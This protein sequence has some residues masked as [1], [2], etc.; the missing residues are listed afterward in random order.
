[1]LIHFLN[2]VHSYIAL[3]GGLI[4]SIIHNKIEAGFYQMTQKIVIIGAGQAAIAFAAK[5]REL[6]QDAEITMIG[7][8]PSLPYQ[9]PPLSKK[10]MTG[11]MEADRL[12]LRPQAWYEEN[13]VSCVA[14]ETVYSIDVENKQIVLEGAS[15]PYDKLLIAT[16]SRP[17]ELP[18]EIGGFLDGV[19]TLRDLE[20]ADAIGAEI[21][22]GKQVLI[23]GGGYI[24]LE[25]AAV[26][27][28]KG[29]K[30]RVVEMADRILQRV[31]ASQ[32]SDFI[33]A[34]HKSEGVEISENL[35]LDKLI[36][37]EGRVVGA[38]FS[39]GSEMQVDFVLAG[40]GAIANME[41]A[42][43]AG[44][45]CSSGIDVNAQTQTSNEDIFAAGDV[46]AFNFREHNV[47]LESVQNAIDQA[48]HAAKVIAGDT[49]DYTPSPWFWSDQYDIKLQ[50]AGFN[51]GYDETVVRDGS[52]SGGQST[53]Y[54]A[55]GKF[56]AVDAMNDP[57]AYM[58][59]KKI[60]ESGNQLTPDQAKDA[61]FDL[62]SLL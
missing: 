18:A 39:D 44:L 62:K 45:S 3:G 29:M 13:K 50:I 37:K 51:I 26:C 58:F 20:D 31:A 34:K 54:F 25:A 41:L 47:R 16:G 53:W 17:R 15:L 57:K 14:G 8:E 56:I 28:Q 6:D 11:D 36:E 30:V 33:R 38:K 2:I 49:S 24:G 9:R 61:E 52:R 59:G 7:Q 32:T 42:Q 1:M 27:S 40:I 21:G 19:Y 10:Y 12:L 55:D 23:I 48:E 4:V 35:G 46:A 60:L 43:E 5:M 22:E